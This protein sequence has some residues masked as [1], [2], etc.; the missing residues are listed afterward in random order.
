VTYTEGGLLSAQTFAP[1]GFGLAPPMI[2][3]SLNRQVT[4][5][6]L[7]WV[8]IDGQILQSFCKEAVVWKHLSCPHIVLFI[9]VTFEPLQLVFE[10]MPGES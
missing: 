8:L 2:G 3:R 7:G 9:G 4:S 10:W 1:N 6:T 5:S